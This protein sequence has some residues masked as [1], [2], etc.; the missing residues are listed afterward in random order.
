MLVKR[1]T[2]VKQRSLVH[3]FSGTL[4]VQLCPIFQDCYY[5][6]NLK[7]EKTV[8]VDL[9]CIPLSCLTGI[10]VA[11]SGNVLTVS[12]GNVYQFDEAGKFLGCVA[13]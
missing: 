3:S 7:S 2:S 13:R 1:K 10:A 5:V 11:K 12:N 9:A 8:K 4:I 6:T